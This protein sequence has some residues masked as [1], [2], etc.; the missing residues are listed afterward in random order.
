MSTVYYPVDEYCNP[1][2][3]VCY[4]GVAPNPMASYWLEQAQ[5]KDAEAF[6]ATQALREANAQLAAKDADAAAKRDEQKAKLDAWIA[7][8]VA[9]R[10]RG[11]PGFKAF[12]LKKRRGDDKFHPLL[13][14]LVKNGVLTL[15]KAQLAM[16]GDHFPVVSSELS[17][18]CAANWPFANTKTGNVANGKT[19][20]PECGSQI[21]LCEALLRAFFTSVDDLR[22]ALTTYD[23]PTLLL[24]EYWC[25]AVAAAWARLHA[26]AE[27]ALEQAHA[28]L[29]LADEAGEKHSAMEFPPLTSSTKA[30]NAGTAK[31]KGR[32]PQGVKP[33]GVKPQGRKPKV[34]K[35]KV[36]KPTAG[37]PSAVVAGPTSA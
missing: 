5:Q 23:A 25:S 34:E 1:F 12:D 16:Q 10:T 36:E 3:V 30:D 22:T 11:S 18:W 24:V 28:W 15:T 35:P 27:D 8:L 6:A 26:G 29:S 13:Q 9:L 33:Q 32:K 4:A 31:P 21:G 37:E 17:S 14:K 20:I 2:R 19:D 7:E